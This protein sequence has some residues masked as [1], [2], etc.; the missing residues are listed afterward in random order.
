[1]ALDVNAD[2]ILFIRACVLP[3]ILEPLRTQTTSEQLDL[4]E[5]FR[6]ELKVAL[7]RFFPGPSCDPK[8][9]A[10]DCGRK[11]IENIRSVLRHVQPPT[12]RARFNDVV[13][14]QARTFEGEWARWGWRDGHAYRRRT[15]HQ[16][17][18]WQMRYQAWR[19]G[20]RALG[21]GFWN[22]PD[23]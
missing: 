13:C 10:R 23:T 15:H 12:L 17:P 7:N 6:T 11:L 8:I 1:M 22:P 9:T 21:K 5:S 18:A 14:E 2:P 19:E 16:T 4:L 20:R 3:T